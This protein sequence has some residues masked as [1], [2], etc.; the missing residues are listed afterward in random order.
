[1]EDMHN[2]EVREE[3]NMGKKRGKIFFFCL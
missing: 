1:M 2:R 3:I